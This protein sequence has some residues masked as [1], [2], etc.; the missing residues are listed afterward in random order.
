MKKDD[1]Y[2][3]C[4]YYKRD[5]RQSVHCEGIVDGTGLRLGFGN[6]GNLENYKN[7]FCRR[8]WTGCMLAKMLNVKYDYT[9]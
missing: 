9:P 8:N 1:T 2:A 6:K 7:T 3:E 5:G 4:P